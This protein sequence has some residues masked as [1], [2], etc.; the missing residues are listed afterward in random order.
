MKN[1]KSVL[2]IAIVALVAVS[3]S[4]TPQK[5]NTLKDALDGK[6]VIGAA[7]DS[8]Q[9][10]GADTAALKIVKEHFNSIVAENCM[11]SMNIQ[12]QE[13]VFTFDL[14]DQF[15][16]FGEENNMNIIGHCLIWHSQAPRWF[17]VDEKGKD[18]S[19]EVLIERMKNHISTVVGRY[20]GR[21][22]GW[23]V[24][25]EAIMEDGSLRKSKF[26]EIIGEDFIKLA[27]QFA[28]EADPDAELY[29]N[30]YNEWHVGKRDSIVAMI[31]DFQADSIRIDAI[32]MQGHFGMDYPQLDEYQAAIDAYAAT[33]V[34][35]MITELDMSALPRPGQN[36]GANITD[37]EAYQAEFNPFTEGLSEE[38]S[39]EWN[40]RMADFFQLFIDNSDKIQRVTMWGVSDAT[41]WKN[42]FPVRGRTDYPLLFDRN[43]Q[44]KPI[45]QQII[46]MANNKVEG[47]R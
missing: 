36:T 33:G 25:N 2:A 38:V 9:I 6:F 15:V 22:H 42:N 19:R 41:S 39:A 7:M 3:C 40:K 4:V 1:L 18:V 47:A 8:S 21:V 5:P 29:Y 45:V 28:H 32:G 27:F 31:K 16:K 46:D 34:K 30:D 13:G 35:V 43:H 17:F 24:V 14:A 26:Y 11:K 44:A 12:P 10:V 20:K 37:I 23:D